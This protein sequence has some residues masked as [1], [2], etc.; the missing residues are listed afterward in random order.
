VLVYYVGAGIA[1]FSVKPAMGVAMSMGMTW[2]YVGINTL[3]TAV[4]GVVAAAGIA[5]IYYELRLIKEGAGPQQ[6]AAVFS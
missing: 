2:A 4:V 5:S 3:I 6:V 1:Q